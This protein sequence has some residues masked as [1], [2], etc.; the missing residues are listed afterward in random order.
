MDG[1]NRNEENNNES[2]G[3][4][5]WGSWPSWL[6]SAKEKSS[7]ALEF[8][9]RDL[10]E[11]SHVVQ[12]DAVAAVSST[13]AMLK[14]KLTVDNVEAVA[15]KARQSVT[16]VIGTIADVFAP[17][18]ELEDDELMIIQN[19]EPVVMDWWQSQI[20]LIRKDPKTFCHEPEGPPEMYENWLES[21]DPSE[22]QDEMTEIMITCSEVRDIYDKLVPTSVSHLEF[23]QR[24]FYRVHLLRKAEAKR[25][26]LMRRADQISIEDVEFDKDKELSL[27]YPDGCE[28]NQN[29]PPCDNELIIGTSQSKETI[30]EG[31]INEKTVINNKSDDVP[32]VT[33]VNLTD[34]KMDNN[35]APNE[36]DI[37]EV[38]SFPS[39]S[40]STDGSRSSP[41]ESL[42]KDYST[43]DEWEKDFDIEINENDLKNLNI[44]SN[45]DSQKEDEDDWEKW[46]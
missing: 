15:D 35:V 40:E 28:A 43:G 44:A 23:W 22:H 33:S 26:D 4:S 11:F 10:S 2:N 8:M 17:Q 34:N 19:S 39:S 38:S 3:N 29:Q 25:T 30:K 13:A 1:A 45:Q 36:N 46:Q 42:G 16:S 41:I 21:F 9:K 18:K 20:Y 5:W 37:T 27:E 7:N 32:E 12:T 6:Q 24:Y 31:N 14:E